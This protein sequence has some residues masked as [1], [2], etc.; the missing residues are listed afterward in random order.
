MF[1]QEQPIKIDE[2]GTTGV[3]SWKFFL[4]QDQPLSCWTMGR[5][6]EPKGDF[7][8]AWVLGRDTRDSE[9]WLIINR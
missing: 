2:S 3:G 7:S 9:Q 4:R 1:V 6:S 8:E 5:S